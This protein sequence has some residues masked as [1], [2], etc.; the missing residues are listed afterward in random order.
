MKICIL[1][2]EKSGDNYGALLCENLR[3]IKEDI[4][5][6]GTGGKEMEKKGVEIIEGMPFGYMGFQ[7]IIKK[8][9]NYLI[10]MKKVIKRIEEQKPDAI[11]FIDNPGFNLQIAKKLNKKYRTFYYIP[12]KIWAHNYERIKVLKKYID[13]VIPIFPFEVEIYKREKIPYFYSGHPFIDLI[14]DG[15]FIKKNKKFTIGILPGS[16]ME[17]LKYN[18]PVFKKIVERLKKKYQFD[19]LISS[20]DE[21]FENYIR[22]IFNDFQYEVENEVYKVIKKSDLI[23]SVSGTVNLE[24]AYMEK[25]LIIFYKT[26][27]LNYFLAKLLVKINTISPLNIILGEKFF[28]EYIQKFNLE[29]V[30]ETIIDLIEKGE[31]YKKEIEG[32]KRLKEIIKE[33]NVS[34]RIAEFIIERSQN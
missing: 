16:R 4:Y 10:F 1:A 21:N 28:P 9:F 19:V 5:F 31:I 22:K 24:V 34:R 13:F 23:L 27:L 32:F 29:E 30:E 25:F 7:S 8:F 26:S 18:L 12:P 17:E 20:I 33:K 14:K 3:K 6:F 11:I 15:N 2:G